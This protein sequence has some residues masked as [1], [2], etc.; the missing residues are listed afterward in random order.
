MSTDSGIGAYGRVADI[1]VIRPPWRRS[2]AILVAPRSVR[3]FEAG[4][5]ILIARRAGARKNSA[6]TIVISWV[7]RQRPRTVGFAMPL[8]KWAEAHRRPHRLQPMSPGPRRRALAKSLQRHGLAVDVAN[9]DSRLAAGQRIILEQCAS[10]SVRPAGKGGYTRNRLRQMMIFGRATGEILATASAGL[11]GALSFSEPSVAVPASR[12][13]AYSALNAPA[14]G[15]R[16][17]RED[18]AGLT[19]HEGQAKDRAGRADRQETQRA[20]AEQG[21][22]PEG[23]RNRPTTRPPSR[24]WIPRSGA[25]EGRPSR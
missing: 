16:C 4:R 3:L 12:A 24:R 2:L 10:L 14:L 25:A 11:H 13:D 7:A 20:P 6:E 18:I 23:A 8:L 17:I 1:V 5:P 19:R 15:R 22:Q 9:I 21:R